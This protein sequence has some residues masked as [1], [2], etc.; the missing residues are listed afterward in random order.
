MTDLKHL[1]EDYKKQNIALSLEDERALIYE[2][3]H[4][5]NKLEGNKLTLAQTTSILEK[6]KLSGTDI[7]L[8]DV[9]EQKGTYKA[10]IRMLKAVSDKEELS[11]ELII[12]LNWLILG[13]LWKDDYYISYKEKGQEFGA[14]KSVNNRI[15]ITDALGKETIINPLSTPE[16]VAL[17]MKMMLKRIQLSEASVIDK[18]SFLAQELWLHQPFIDGNKRTSRL[19]INFLTMQMGYPLFVFASK[20]ENFNDILVRQYTNREEGLLVKYIQKRLTH[21]MELNI[22]KFSGRDAKSSGFRMLL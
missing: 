10:L 1:L 3:V 6:G 14:L 13:P 12:E 7:N 21:Q 18:A 15:K 5:T 9:L 22:K 11:V 4:A 19:L 17:N 16:N 8:R 20:G 2:Y